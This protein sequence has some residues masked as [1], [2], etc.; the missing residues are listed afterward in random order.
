MSGKF[1][2]FQ[3]EKSKEFYFRLK[4]GNGQIILQSEG[5]TTKSNCQKG[6]ASVMKN[7]AHDKAYDISKAN[8]FNLKSIDNGQIIGTSQTYKTE[9]GRDKGI[10][11][12]KQNAPAAEIVDLT[13]SEK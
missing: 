10:E 1:E 5:Y 3:S 7:A 6:I 4:A 8:H 2:I 13:V 11:S 12:V 9:D